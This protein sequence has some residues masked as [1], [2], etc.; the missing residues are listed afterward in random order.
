MNED[1][2]FSVMRSIQNFENRVEYFGEE[3]SN[4]SESKLE[5]KLSQVEKEYFS[6]FENEKRTNFE[7][8]EAEHWKDLIGTLSEKLADAFAIKSIEIQ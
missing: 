5:N 6:F 7:E 2:I 1:Q 3:I 4:I 8:V